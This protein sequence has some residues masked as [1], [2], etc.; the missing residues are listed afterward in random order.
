[1]K[2]TFMLKVGEARQSHSDEQWK[3]LSNDMNYTF[4]PED[5][6]LLMLNQ[7]DDDGDDDNSMRIDFK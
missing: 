7:D 1:M 5:D 4:I 6:H 2:I 3:K